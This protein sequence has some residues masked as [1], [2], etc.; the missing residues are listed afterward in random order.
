MKRKINLQMFAEDTATA[1]ET[2]NA[3]TETA[4]EGKDTKATETA[5]EKKYTDADVDRIVKQRLARAEKEQ[6]KAVEEA[7]AKEKEAARL[8]KMNA[9][10]KAEYELAE[11]KKVIAEYERK[12]TIAEMTSTARNMLADDN[13]SVPDAVL[14]MLVTTD[15]DET[16]AAVKG[17]SKAFKDAVENAV[18]ERLKGNPPKTSTGGAVANMTKAQIM[19]IKDHELRQKMMLENKHLFNI[20]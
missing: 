13:I 11:A 20:K 2:A 1:T 3:A 7:K 9:Q 12:N 14:S 10:E 17:F 5:A 19:G 6:Q 18:K 15:A 8:E 4:A 16:K